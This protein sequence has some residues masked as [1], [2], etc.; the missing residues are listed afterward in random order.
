MHLLRRRS[1][2]PTAVDFD[3]DRSDDTGEDAPDGERLELPPCA[4]V[5]DKE[6]VARATSEIRSIL[7]KTIA[8]GMEEVGRYLL[9]EFYDDDP[10]LYRSTSHSKHASLRL[11]EAQ[12]E[13][14]DLPV[15]RTFLANAIRIAVLSRELPQGAKFLELPPSHRVELLKLRSHD[16]IERVAARAVEGKLTV[17]RVREIVRKD[18]ERN[19]TTRGRK[20]APPPLA[21][22]RSCVRALRDESTGRLAFRKE[23]FLEMNEGDLDEAA[24]LV[25]V[26]LRRAEEFARL[27]A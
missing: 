10:S 23:E 17:K 2:D 15:R 9:R 13:T 1:S 20:A 24:T 16:K 14:L 25:E 22:I 19:K 7:A 3:D 5:P 12:C 6:L 18:R 4:H 8:R 27:L 11:L 26:L 21:A